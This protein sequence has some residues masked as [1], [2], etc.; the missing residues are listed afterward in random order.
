[1][2]TKKA[3]AKQEPLLNAVARTLGHAAGTLSKATQDFAENLST[4]PATVTTRVQQMSNKDTKRSHTGARAAS[5]KRSSGA[6][7]AGKVKVSAIPG[8]KKKSQKSRAS[9]RSGKTRARHS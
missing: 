7:S 5:E 8:S 3:P 1:M 2:A 6:R 9:R 4:L